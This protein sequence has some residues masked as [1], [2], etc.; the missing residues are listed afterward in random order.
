MN[1]I[2]FISVFVQNFYI[3]SQRYNFIKLLWI[4]YSFITDFNAVFVRYYM[5][6]FNIFNIVFNIDMQ[7]A[8]R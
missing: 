4:L 7:Y 1:V 2:Q 6:V 8:E 3:I 5:V